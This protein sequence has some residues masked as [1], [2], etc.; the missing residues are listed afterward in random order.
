MWQ[1][2]TTSAET[3][4][5]FGRESS[6]LLDGA[7]MPQELLTLGREIL[8]EMPGLQEEI[9]RRLVGQEIKV[10]LGNHDV[11]WLRSCARVEEG[12][13]AT[14]CV[15]CMLCWNFRRKGGELFVQLCKVFDER[16]DT[17]VDCII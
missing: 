2:N 17:F 1:R 11:K 4:L 6:E 5:S 10:D 7:D 13:E 12:M 15:C 16:D 8:Q 14:V 3:N 9:L